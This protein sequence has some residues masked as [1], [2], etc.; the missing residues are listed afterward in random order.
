MTNPKEPRGFKRTKKQAE[1]LLENNEKLKTLLSSASEKAKTKQ[2]SLKDVWNNFQTLL[3]LVKAW[4]KKEY[5]E[6][7]WQ[8]IL[9][10]TAAILYFVSP[11]DLI[12]DFIPLT[13]FIDDVSVITFVVNSIRKDIKKFEAWE[14]E[15]LL[16]EK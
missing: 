4:W 15:Q 11:F 9:Y 6:I 10:A 14:K 13:G 16:N 3:R 12:P 2:K 1:E 7:P 5:T 8:T